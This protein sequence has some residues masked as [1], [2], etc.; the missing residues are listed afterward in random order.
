MLKRLLFFSFCDFLPEKYLLHLITYAASFEPCLCM[1][2]NPDKFP[3]EH[4]KKF[5][6]CFVKKSTV[7]KSQNVYLQRPSPEETIENIIADMDP[8]TRTKEFDWYKHPPVKPISLHL[9]QN[10]NNSLR[11]CSFE[12]TRASSL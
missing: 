12:K 9:K 7:F 8:F 3:W 5:S 10:K 6:D 4:T 2:Q 1:T 11:L